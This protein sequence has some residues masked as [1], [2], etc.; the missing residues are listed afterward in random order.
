MTT[1]IGGD[2]FPTARAIHCNLQNQP[3]QAGCHDLYGNI[4]ILTHVL[5]QTCRGA[6]AVCAS[7]SKAAAPW[8]YDAVTLTAAYGSPY[9]L[10]GGAWQ[11]RRSKS[12]SDTMSRTCF[13]LCAGPAYSCGFD[14]V[15]ISTVNMDKSMF[16]QLAADKRNRMR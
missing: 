12:K 10:A 7:F 5:S 15:N 16:F 3:R 11:I 1:A 8:D 14:S 6:P 9:L 4:M 2:E 13:H